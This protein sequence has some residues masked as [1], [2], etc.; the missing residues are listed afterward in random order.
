MPGQGRV[1]TLPWCVGVSDIN[2][3]NYKPIERSMVLKAPFLTPTENFDTKDMVKLY[4][5]VADS[6][7]LLLWLTDRDAEKKVICNQQ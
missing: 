7:V 4:I 1:E 3:L 5:N 6:S 2:E